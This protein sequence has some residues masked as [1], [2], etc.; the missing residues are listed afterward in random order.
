MP[1]PKFG[2]TCHFSPASVVDAS[3]PPLSSSRAGSCEFTSEIGSLCK[4]FGIPQINYSRLT[5]LVRL[6]LTTVVLTFIASPIRTGWKRSR[7]GLEGSAQNDSSEL[8]V[9]FGEGRTQ[10]HPNTKPD[11]PAY[12]GW[13]SEHHGEPPV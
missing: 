3:T 1:S 10:L 8:P 11:D 5:E 13:G 2:T 9:D 4:S 7:T 6:S 12:Q